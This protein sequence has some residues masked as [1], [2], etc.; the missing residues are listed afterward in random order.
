MQPTTMPHVIAAHNEKMIVLRPEIAA[1]SMSVSRLLREGSRGYAA[2]NMLGSVGAGML[3]AAL[4]L[5]LGRS[6]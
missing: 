2:W 1:L 5:W 4:G 3:L 6:I